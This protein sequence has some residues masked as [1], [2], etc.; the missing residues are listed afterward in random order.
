[1]RHLDAVV[2]G[3]TIDDFTDT[4]AAGDQFVLF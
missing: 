4:T 3:T 1:M 2:G